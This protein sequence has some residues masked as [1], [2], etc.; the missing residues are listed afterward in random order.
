MK[1]NIIFCL[2]TL[3]ISVISLPS[4]SREHTPLKAKKQPLVVFVCGD[5]E[6]S[7]ESTLPLLAAVLEKQYGFRTKVLKSFPDQNWKLAPDLHRG[8]EPQNKGNSRLLDHR[9][10]PR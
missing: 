4:F 9:K 3:F 10:R 8:G 2:A 1:K 5:H 6:Y 7:G